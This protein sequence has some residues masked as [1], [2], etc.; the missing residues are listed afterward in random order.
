[1]AR[2]RARSQ[3]SS[4]R[5]T[6]F[7]T[8]SAPIPAGALADRYG[9]GRFLLAAYALASL[10]N[11][12]LIV[13]APSIRDAPRRLHSRGGG[14]C[15]SAIARAG[16]RC[17]PDADRGAEHRLRRAGLCKWSRRPR[18]KRHRRNA[19]DNDFPGR[20]ILLRAGHERRRRDRNGRCA[21]RRRSSM[22]GSDRTE[23]FP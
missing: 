19:V 1:M 5:C 16:D 18:L 9:K 23:R 7:F 4:M 6:T 15:A 22:L 8:P 3:S 11:L 2:G 10:M 14:L 17:G 20:R 13:A 12:I 21:T